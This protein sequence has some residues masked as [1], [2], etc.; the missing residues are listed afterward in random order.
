VT[1]ELI[2]VDDLEEWRD[3]S[4][5]AR[6]SKSPGFLSDLGEGW[7][8]SSIGR[9]IG[10]S[11]SQASESFALSKSLLGGGVRGKLSNGSLKI[12]RLGGVG[13]ACGVEEVVVEDVWCWCW[14]YT[15]FLFLGDGVIAGLFW[16]Y[17][18][19]RFD[20]AMAM[21]VSD[22]KVRIVAEQS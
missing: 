14:W 19:N 1:F 8:S 6:F 3:V 15:T 4:L 2:L 20:A 12:S 22:H 11:V 13:G 16:L 21:V 7:G 18:W 10:E 5:C 17:F 9:K